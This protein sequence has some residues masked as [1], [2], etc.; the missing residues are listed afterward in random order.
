MSDEIED[1]GK[2]QKTEKQEGNSLAPQLRPYHFKPGQSGNPAGR[3]KGRSLLS[4]ILEVIN[5]DK[6]GA[7]VAL[8]FIE[9]LKRGSFPHHKE[10]I[11]RQEGKVPEKVELQADVNG[12]GEIEIMAGAG[13]VNEIMADALRRRKESG[14]EDEKTAAG[15]DDKSPSLP[16]GD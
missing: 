8:A 2:S 4:R 13:V 16:S 3:P 7:E 12:R 15:Q 10:I 9:Q 6:E 11:E 5:D 1:Q 14:I